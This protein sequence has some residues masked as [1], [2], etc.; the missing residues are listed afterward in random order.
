VKIVI[1]GMQIPPN[2]GEE[3]AQ[4]FRAVF[5]ELARSNDAALIPFL[6]E[7]VGGRSDLN[8]GDQIHPHPTAAGGQIV[9]ENVW[10]VLRPLL[11]KSG[12]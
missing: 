7:G 6:L 11:R 1:A 12:S 10:R 2:L 3:Y 5:A 4:E 9:A 8:Q